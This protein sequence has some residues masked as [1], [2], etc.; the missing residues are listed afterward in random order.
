MVS[1]NVK[2]FELKLGRAGLVIVIVGMAALL[3]C[4]FIFGVEVG[5][6]IDAYPEK[7][8]SLPQQLLTL[9]WRPA[10]I[11]V[12]Q[13]AV[14]NKTVQSQPKAQEEP[15]LTFFNTLTSKKGAAK[16]QSIVNKKP[17]AAAP[18]TQQLLPKPK[19]DTSATPVNSNSEVKKQ[20][21]ATP[22]KTGDEI[23]AKIKEA[24]PKVTAKESKSKF[25]IQAASMKE[26]AKAD[27]LN[28]KIKAMGFTTRIVENDVPGK[29]KWFRIVVEGF[30]SK[31][32]AQTAA[33][34]ISGKTGVPGIIKN[35][36]TA[37]NNN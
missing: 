21:Q 33:A 12:A 25:V 11:R 1:G 13:N 31:E 19:S 9:V 15:D 2:N 37:T 17:V 22:V 28:K 16:E 5:K 36:N 29:G 6:N 8:A 20:K 35:I 32:N 4:T 7:I 18:A 30:P 24:E 34:K 10:K 27:E 14:E 26:K 23:E 3:C